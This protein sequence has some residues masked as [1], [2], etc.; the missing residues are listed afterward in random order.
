MIAGINLLLEP[1]SLYASDMW[2]I[3]TKFMEHHPYNPNG[4][5]LSRKEAAIVSIT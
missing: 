3:I 2:K 5:E 1:N 4:D